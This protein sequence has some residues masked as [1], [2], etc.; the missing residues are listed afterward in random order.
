MPWRTAHVRDADAIR[1][2]HLLRP[3]K[4]SWVNRARLS[5]FQ[6]LPGQS[7]MMVTAAEYK[8][9]LMPQKSTAADRRSIRT[10]FTRAAR[11]SLSEGGTRCSSS[12]DSIWA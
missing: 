7:E 4:D 3:I 5:V 12:R 8:L 2:E 11:S 1:Q 6:R 9:G 10:R